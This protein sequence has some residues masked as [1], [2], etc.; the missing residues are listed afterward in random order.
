MK[1]KE[2]AEDY[3]EAIL[4]LEKKN[5]AVQSVDIIEDRKSVV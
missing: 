1:I 3:L 4:I 5:G 2:S